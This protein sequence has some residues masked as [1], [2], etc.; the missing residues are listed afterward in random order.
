MSDLIVVWLL[1][2]ESLVSGSDLLR[3]PR[4]VRN[5]S[6]IDIARIITGRNGSGKGIL[7][8][9]ATD[10]WCCSDPADRA[11][12]SCGLSGAAVSRP[13]PS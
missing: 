8:F 10:S 3:I 5:A 1:T 4:I 6:A 13:R 12:G 9:M 2:P 7:P 11:T